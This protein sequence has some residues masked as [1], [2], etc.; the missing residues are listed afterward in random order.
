MSET[1]ANAHES[2][3]CMNLRSVAHQLTKRYDEALAPSGLSITQFAQLRQLLTAEQPTVKDLAEASGLDRSTL[4]RNIKVM[5]RMGLVSVSVGKDARTRTINVTPGGLSAFKQAEP[6]WQAV[7]L[8]LKTD[9]GA[10]GLG[11][12]DHLLGSLSGGK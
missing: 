8:E 10:G 4:G 2:C 9:L 5:E 12:L 3:L 6:L 7:Q 1:S 11:L